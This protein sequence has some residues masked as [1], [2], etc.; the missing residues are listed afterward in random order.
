MTLPDFIFEKNEECPI[1]FE[2]MNNTQVVCTPCNHIFHKSCLEQQFSSSYFN[3]FNCSICRENLWD[4]LSGQQQ[5]QYINLPSLDDEN[6]WG[7]E[8]IS[9]MNTFINERSLFQSPRPSQS[10]SI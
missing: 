8:I 9:R 2:N 6:L 5:Q 10:R 1:C 3:S 7:T 4:H